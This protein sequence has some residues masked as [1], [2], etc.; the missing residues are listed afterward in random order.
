MKIETKN[1]CQKKTEKTGKN[2]LDQDQSC[3]KFSFCSIILIFPFFF[4][5]FLFFFFWFFFPVPTAQIIAYNTVL[6]IECLP[7]SCYVSPNNQSIRNNQRKAILVQKSKKAI[8][9]PKQLSLN[10]YVSTNCY[11]PA[12]CYAFF[13]TNCNNQRAVY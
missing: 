1:K 3:S 10:C 6:L 5:F 11:I 7:P 9:I 13:L 2:P 8:S 12:N 4:I